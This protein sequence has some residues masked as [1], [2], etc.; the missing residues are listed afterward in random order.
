LPP[1]SLSMGSS[2]VMPVMTVVTG[3][4]SGSVTPATAMSANMWFGGHMSGCGGTGSANAPLQSGAWL[5][6]WPGA[7]VVVV[8]DV[9]VVVGGSVL[10]VVLLEVEVVVVEVDV[11]EVVVVVC[12]LEG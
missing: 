1:S 8:D 12:F 11:V 4:P 9:L 5:S 7:V 2:C 6:A 3:S 10:V